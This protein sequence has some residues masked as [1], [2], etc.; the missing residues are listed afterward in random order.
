MDALIAFWSHALAAVLFVALMIWRLGEASRQPG[1][2]LLVG[3]FAMTACWA[4]LSA[5][6][7]A[8]PWSAMPKAP[9]TCSGSA[10]STA[11]RAPARTASTA[12]AW[13]MARSP[14]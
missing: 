13:S 6:A 7:P 10:C 8:R 2:R 9:A 4:W 1:Q 3:A 14:R 11:C 5:V 12:S